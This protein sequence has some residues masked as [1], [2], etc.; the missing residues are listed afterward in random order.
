MKIFFKAIYNMFTLYGSFDALRL[1]WN[2][3][4]ILVKNLV[5]LGDMDTKLAP[6][7]FL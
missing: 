7:N 6:N 3:L 4:C 1:L 2:Y 5:P